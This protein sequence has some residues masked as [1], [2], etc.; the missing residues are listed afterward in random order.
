MP[1]KLPPHNNEAENAVI[2]SIIIDETCL[3]KIVPLLKPDDFHQERARWAYEAILS[4]RQRG[5]GIDQLTV[6]YELDRLDHLEAVSRD[7]LSRISA[8]LPTSV[9]AV[10]YTGIV[11]EMAERRRSIL[12]AARLAAAAYD[13][14]VIK[15]PTKKPTI[16]GLPCE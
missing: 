5:L 2:A 1:D 11:A 13:G 3:D 8:A 7:Y 10:Y 16:L 14:T 12:E 6:F 9:H 4:L 15:K